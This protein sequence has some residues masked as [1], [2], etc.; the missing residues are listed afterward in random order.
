MSVAYPMTQAVRLYRLSFVTCFG[1]VTDMEVI[2]VIICVCH[3]AI[4]FGYSAKVGIF[5]LSIKTSLLH[6]YIFTQQSI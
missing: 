4:G 5:Q 1:L 6:A 2:K 3:V